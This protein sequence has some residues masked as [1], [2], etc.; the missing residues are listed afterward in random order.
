MRAEVTPH[1][2]AEIAGNY[3][4]AIAWVES[5]GFP[6]NRGRHDAYRKTIETLRTRFSTQGWGD[7]T[8]DAYRDEVCTALLESRELV[9]IYRGFS[10]SAD[11]NV[12]PQLR[13][14][15]KGPVFP[16]HEQAENSSNRARNFGF[17][18]YLTAL[19]AYAGFEPTYGTNADLS[20][21]TD[22]LRVFVEAKR[23]MTEHAVHTSLRIA[24]RQ[25]A[26]RFSEG[27]ESDQAGIVALDLSKVINPRNLVMPVRNEDQLY[28]LMYNEDKLQMDRLSPTVIKHIEPGV[29]GL[30][31][32]YRLLT[33]F[34]PHGALNTLKWIG[35]VPFIQD[36]GL[37]DIHV[38]LSGVVRHIC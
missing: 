12:L 15:M 4:A 28:E 21:L 11:A 30:L 32:H 17:E 9:S 33:V 22:R 7:F 29:V 2:L 1:T 20:F 38:R 19:F 37:D 14:Y 24:M 34:E 3:Q 8:N 26:S 31:L 6:V 27:D 16:I 36:R 23:P 10:G 25:L 18:L 5:I 13:H 35:W